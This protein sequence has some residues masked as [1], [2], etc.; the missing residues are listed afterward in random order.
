MSYF[1]KVLVSSG[2]CK[3][4]RVLRLESK[5]LMQGSVCMDAGSSERE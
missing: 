4:L 2:A 3:F 5:G 1:V